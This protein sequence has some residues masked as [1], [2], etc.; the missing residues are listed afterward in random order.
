MTS[1]GPYLP[2][3]AALYALPAAISIRTP[4]RISDSDFWCSTGTLAVWLVPLLNIGISTIF[5]LLRIFT[6]VILRQGLD[7]G[8]L[9]LGSSVV[10]DHGIIASGDGGIS[11]LY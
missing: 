8:D 9:A 3:R 11:D 1:P 10:R 7:V 2:C 4:D 6:R 5:Y